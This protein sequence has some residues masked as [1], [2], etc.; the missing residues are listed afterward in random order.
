MEVG[1]RVD[2]LPEEAG[3]ALEALGQFVQDACQD[4]R[5][6]DARRGL[7]VARTI[8]H[9]MDELMF[10]DAREREGE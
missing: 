10:V 2:L 9:D 7:H 1:Y 3:V 4:G 6:E 8:S 5:A